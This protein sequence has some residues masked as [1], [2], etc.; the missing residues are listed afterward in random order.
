MSTKTHEFTLEGGDGLNVSLAAEPRA[1]GID[2]IR[3]RWKSDR[4]STPPLLTL[5]WVHSARDVQASW[6]PA[7][8]RNKSFKADWMRE[9]RSNATASAPVYA[10][11]DANGTN[12]M[13]FAF[14]D[15]LN[16]VHYTGGIREETAEFQCSVQ[17]FK[18][19][20][21]PIDAYEAELLVDTR[22]IPYFD[23]LSDVRRWWS[24]MPGYAPAV[25]PETARRPM[26]STWYSMHQNVTAEEVE[27]E[28]RIAR[29]LGMEAVI[30]DDGWQT[31]DNR[32][33]YAYTGDW[34]PCEG[35]FPDMRRH[36]EAVHALGMKFL[37]WFAVPYVGIYSGT[38]ERFKDKLVRFNEGSRAG[39]LDP[40]YPE[41]R[42][43]IIATYEEAVRAWDLDGLKLDFVDAFYAPEREQPSAVPGRDC[44]SI[45]AAVDR[46]LTAAIGRLRSL[47]PDILIEFRQPYVGPAMRKHGNMFRASDCPYDSIQNRVRTLDIRLLCGET[48]A[49]AD[50]VMWHPEEPVESAAL[51]LINLLFSVPQI[52]MR[53]SALPPAHL[54]M[55]RRWLAF[56]EEH[57]E[58]L[59]NGRLEPGNPAL[60][61]PTVQAVKGD[62]AVIVT[63]H[64]ALVPLRADRPVREWTVVNGRQREE[65]VLEVSASLG[66]ANIEIANSCGD[67]VDRLCVNLDLGLHRLPIP[68]AG[69]ASIRF[70]RS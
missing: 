5:R 20:A 25:V 55:L 47:K 53:L 33:G 8:D 60:S 32:R 37:L 58:V 10:L 70:G 40:R 1:D 49:H 13:T 26:Y 31:E 44:V 67:I 24:G 23:C 7:P 52:S 57:R 56:W 68:A 29:T 41:V 21:E 34:T 38:W 2:L 65:V 42:E 3:L 30:V 62:R 54:R 63:Y 9:L 28:C 4:P 22:A 6:H 43:F 69:T 27:A 46:L 66:E 19:A 16:T 18:E 14:S 45:P 17:L 48:A 35:K 39:V 50:M 64:D 12:R 11:F 36:V 59:L 51:Q 15:A 61:Y